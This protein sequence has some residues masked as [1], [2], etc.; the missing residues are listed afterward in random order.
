MA[1]QVQDKEF[2]STDG[3]HMLK[4]KLYLPEG[5]P[6]AIF[7]VVHGMTEHI[8]RYDGFLREMAEAGYLC[9]AYDNLGHGNTAKDDSELGYIAKRDG[10]KKLIADVNA[11][12]NLMKQAYPGLPYYL[13]GHS[14]GSFIVRLATATYP[15]LPDKLII[16]GTGGPNPA[17]KAALGIINLIKCFKGDR[18]ISPFIEK[19]AFGEYNKGFGDGSN[20]DWLSKNP[21]VR[22]VYN[23]DKFCNYHFTVSAMHDLVKLNDLTNSGKWFK[24]M[25]KKCRS[26]P[27]LM[28]SGAEDPVGEHSKGVTT[29]YNKLKKKGMNVTIKLYPDNRH[30]ILNDTAHDEAVADILAFL[31][32]GAE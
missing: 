32:E 19:T 2:P 22:R 31:S 25:K 4:G 10:Y 5:A 23:A 16:M 11:V 29:V 15:D 7:H 24:T 3:Q 18:H 17:S 13:M 26:L 12:G 28:V 30:E 1:V 8:G 21:E 20:G 14:M 9:V 6:K 27:I